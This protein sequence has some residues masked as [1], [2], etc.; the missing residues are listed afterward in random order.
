VARTVRLLAQVTSQVAIMQYPAMS[1]AV[2]RRV[3]IVP[4]H[5]SR[6]LLV[7]VNSLGKVAQRSIDLDS[8]DEDSLAQLRDRLND[9]LTGLGPRK[10]AEA[11]A[12]FTGSVPID[13]RP[14]AVGVV[15]GILDILASDQPTKIVVGGINNLS[16][17]S[18][19]FETSIRPV[20][21]T[22]EEQ[23]V[24]LK[25]LGEASADV[26]VHIGQENEHA[27][28]SSASV[29]ASGYGVDETWAGLGVVGPTRMDYPSTMASVRAVARY[30]SRILAEG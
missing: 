15:A 7:V 22:L 11:L 6:G 10:A 28:L 3:D 12:D 4:L 14:V 8:I 24:L 1:A 27:N 20:L 29:V 13:S 16:Q 5:D 17:F 21:D 30:V 19:E 23:V 25:L 26:T 18:D 9:V 2:V